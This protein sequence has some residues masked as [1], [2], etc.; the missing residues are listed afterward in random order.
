[1]TTLLAAVGDIRATLATDEHA[2]AIAAF[3]RESWS[4]H[5]TAATVLAHRRQAAAENVA[6]PGV[7]PPTALV[8]DGDRVI[9]YC[10]SIPQLLWDG[11]AERPAYWTKGLMVLPEFR[12]GPIGFL[13]CKQLTAQ[14]P[15][16]VGL[17]VAPAARRLFKAAG[18]ADL[19]AV[20][21]HVRLLRPGAV[22]RQIDVGGLGLD[23]PRWLTAMVQSAQRTGVAGL[24]GAAAGVAS[25]L[26][27]RALRRTRGIAASWTAAAPSAAELDAVWQSARGALAAGP[28]RDGRYLRSRFA[29]PTGAEHGRYVF[30][31]AYEGARLAGVA[32]VRQP[33]TGGDPRLRNV[34]VATLSDIVFPPARTD[35]AF[36]LLGCVEH[37]AR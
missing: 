37:A 6:D 19:G 17:V 14:L 35:V 4:Q 33:R 3:Y 25:N 24:A 1:M 11:I 28:V 20:A 15:R 30:C 9:A 36:A 10:G 34:R 22:A 31:G 13:V 29:A 32:V 26:A 7:A 27:A 5:A 8:L 12:N 23:L 2:G 21:N 16:A 18:Y